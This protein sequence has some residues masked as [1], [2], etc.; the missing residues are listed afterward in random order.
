MFRLFEFCF[1]LVNRVFVMVFVV[2]GCLDFLVFVFLWSVVLIF[3][4]WWLF[5]FRFMV[6]LGGWGWFSKMGLLYANY[7]G[8]RT[9]FLGPI[10]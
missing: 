8:P 1:C 7:R 5:W 3:L 2:V 4:V 10:L 9:P 6:F